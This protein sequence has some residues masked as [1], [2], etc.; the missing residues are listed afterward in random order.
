MIVPLFDA[1][2]NSSQIH[3]LSYN[4]H[5]YLQKCPGADVILHCTLY[6]VIARA[7]EI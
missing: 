7:I 2:P 4:L 1:R 6:F 5:G 3:W